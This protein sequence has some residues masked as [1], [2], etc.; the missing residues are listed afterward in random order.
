[1]STVSEHIERGAGPYSIGSD[2]WP[3]LAKLTEECGEVI[4]V[5]GKLIASNGESAH[6]DGTDLR[7]RLEDE[8]A[9]VQAAI[10]FAVDLNGLDRDRML[11]RTADKLAL[12]KHW[13]Q[14][15]AG[16]GA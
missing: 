6:W 8:L 10:Y 1:M 15:H 4:Q 9:D 11:Q 5:A 12:F 13:Q 3:G 2:L 16:S 7:Q 14:E